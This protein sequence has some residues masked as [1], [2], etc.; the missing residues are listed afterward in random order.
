MKKINF[1]DGINCYPFIEEHIEKN[2]YV[3]QDKNIIV[4]VDSLP[5]K[6]FEKKKNDIFIYIQVESY[7]VLS[8]KMV[9][10]WDYDFDLVLA[11]K[12]NNKNDNKNKKN[13]VIKFLPYNKVYWIAPTHDLKKNLNLPFLKPIDYNIKNKKCK[14]SMLCGEKNWAPG[15]IFRREIWLYQEKMNFDKNF[16]YSEKYGDLKL[17]I[18]NK[19][20]SHNKDKTELF[21]DSMFHIAIENNQA[22]DYFT[23]KLIDC[24]VSKTIPIYY[25]CPNIGDYFDIRGMIIVNDM[26]DIKNLNNFISEKFYKDRLEFVEYNYLRVLNRPSFK[27]QFIQIMEKQFEINIEEK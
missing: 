27:E 3:K 4:Y 5:E 11:F 6:K 2:L 24:F 23:E 9:H 10:I 12:Y 13:N 14:V 17:F 18:D 21:I 15:H 26:N 8:H 19:K 25:G 20:I 22:T 1:K 16:K 7:Y